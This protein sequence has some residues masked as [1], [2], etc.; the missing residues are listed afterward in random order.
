MAVRAAALRKGVTGDAG[1]LLRRLADCT[2]R[3]FGHLPICP[4]IH[5]SLRQN[6]GSCAPTSKSQSAEPLFDNPESR[7]RESA[8]I[9]RKRSLSRSRLQHRRAASFW[10]Q[11]ATTFL[12]ACVAFFNFVAT[13][14]GQSARAAS[15]VDHAA[16]KL[17]H[18]RQQ[19]L[20]SIQRGAGLTKQMSSDVLEK[21]A[22]WPRPERVRQLLHRAVSYERHLDVKAAIRCYEVRP[23]LARLTLVAGSSH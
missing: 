23:S 17:R 3:S 5:R 13:S 9:Q 21:M 22:N 20:V 10:W 19:F 2:Q 18:G 1:A 7:G 15:L 8:A 12:A 14:F 4:P 11:L 16:E 6:G